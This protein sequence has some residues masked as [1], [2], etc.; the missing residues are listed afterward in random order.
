MR[1]PDDSDEERLNEIG[2]KALENRLAVVK[3]YAIAEGL[4]I[5]KSYGDIVN[6]F[7]YIPPDVPV[8]AGYGV[9]DGNGHMPTELRDIYF[10]DELDQLE[11]DL[12]KLLD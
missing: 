8:Y 3:L 10:L 11:D 7:S 5:P 12:N 2:I 6:D 4:S 9:I 1:D